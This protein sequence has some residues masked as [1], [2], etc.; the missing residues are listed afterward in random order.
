MFVYSITIPYDGPSKLFSTEEAAERAL[1][2]DEWYG[3]VGA[4]IEVWEVE[5]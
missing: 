4:Y 3:T 5:S 2:A 1:K